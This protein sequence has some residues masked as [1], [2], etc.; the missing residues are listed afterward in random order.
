LQCIGLTLK[1]AWHHRFTLLRQVQEQT[2][3]S[4]RRTSR[5]WPRGPF[6]YPVVSPKSSKCFAFRQVCLS[7]PVRRA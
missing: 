4:K 1:I 6:W 7:V 3:L 2:P 5:T